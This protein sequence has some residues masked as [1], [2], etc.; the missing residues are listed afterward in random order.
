MSAVESPQ[1]RWRFDGTVTLGN[2]LTAVPLII[3]LVGWGFRTEGRGDRLEM[4]IDQV[5]SRIE[6][7]STANQASATEIKSQLRDLGAKLD[8][9]IERMPAPPR[10]R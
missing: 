3:A 5:E 7:E 9:L 8:R 6:R 4:R 10:E 2:I 1:S